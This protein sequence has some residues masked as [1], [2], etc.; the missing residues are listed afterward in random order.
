MNTMAPALFASRLE[1]TER[2][3]VQIVAGLSTSPD[4]VR[5]Q[6]EFGG[7]PKDTET[8]RHGRAPVPWTGNS[9]VGSLTQP[10]SVGRFPRQAGG[11]DVVLSVGRRSRLSFTY[12]RHCVW[13]AVRE[14]Y[15]WHS[16]RRCRPTDRLLRS[17]R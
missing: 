5:L 14:R 15:V 4:L 2:R 6:D 1:I 7:D 13:L 10:N 12:S 17:T 3:G 8:H 9:F 16:V 11:C